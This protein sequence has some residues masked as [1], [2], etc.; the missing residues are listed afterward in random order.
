[1]ARNA[2]MHNRK[3][4][5][6]ASCLLPLL[7]GDLCLRV[8]ATRAGVKACK[9]KGSIDRPVPARHSMICSSIEHNLATTYKGNT[10]APRG[11]LHSRVSQ[12]TG[13]RG[14]ETRSMPP[15][16]DTLRGHGKM[17]LTV[18]P[19]L[20]DPA[21]W[22]LQDSSLREVTLLALFGEEVSR[23]RLSCSVYLAGHFR[24]NQIFHHEE[25]R[26]GSTNGEADGKHATQRTSSLAS[27]CDG[28]V[29]RQQN[30]KE[31]GMAAVR[32]GSCR[33]SCS[34]KEPHR[35]IQKSFAKIDHCQGNLKHRRHPFH[36][37]TNTQLQPQINEHLVLKG[38]P[39]I[40]L[41]IGY[42]SLG[43]LTLRP[44]FYLAVV[45]PLS[46]GKTTI[47]VFGDIF[48]RACHLVVVN[49]LPTALE[50]TIRLF[51]E[52]WVG[53]GGDGGDQSVSSP[54]GQTLARSQTAWLGEAGGSVMVAHHLE[55]EGQKAAGPDNIPGR[56]LRECADQLADVLTD[57]FN[58][59]LSCTIVPICFKT[60]T[61][62]P[63]PKKFKVSCLNDYSPVALTSII[64]KCFKKLVMRHVKTQLPPSLDPLQF[65]YRS[66]HSTDNAISTTCHLALTYLDKKGTY[67]RM[68]FIDFSSAFNTIVSQHLIGKLSLLGLNTSLLQLDPGLLDW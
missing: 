49:K 25:K 3:N 35:K 51:N 47:L 61:I 41:A 13:Q 50:K 12:E 42:P 8:R 30:L 58:I 63:M 45:L 53:S 5:R 66:N 34:G 46:N 40:P 65:A 48:T 7:L 9:S 17:A 60:T 20:E 67:V 22:L 15:K 19:C 57:I 31:D 44:W 29:K 1:M 23:E 43:I 11:A 64:M 27:C 18:G 62:V 10:H 24:K 14:N 37:S 54:P 33:T 26:H 55:I 6:P 16:R 59:S 21:S 2:A 32:R 36:R 38:G 39:R 28:K 4:G 52:V 56:V 68:L